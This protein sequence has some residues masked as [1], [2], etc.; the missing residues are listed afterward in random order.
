MLRTARKLEKLDFPFAT[1]NIILLLLF[2]FIVTGSIVGKNETSVA[3]PLTSRL[4]T[5]RLPRPLLVIDKAG[6]LYLDEVPTS[7]PRAIA[8]MQSNAGR[9]AQRH[10]RPHF[11]GA[12]LSR[13][14]R[15]RADRRHPRADHNAQLAG[16]RM[17]LKRRVSEPAKLYWAIGIAASIALHASG[18]AG[19]IL[20]AERSRAG[21][22]ADR[23]HLLGRG[24]AGRHAGAGARGNAPQRAKPRRWP[25][26]S[27]LPR[28]ARRLLAGS[29]AETLQAAGDGR[30]AAASAAARGHGKP[31]AGNRPAGCFTG[32]RRRGQGREGHGR[33]RQPR[34]SPR[35][36]APSICPLRGRQTRPLRSARPRK[37][38]PR[39]TG[40]ERLPSSS[41]ADAA[42][43]VWR[44]R[45]KNCGAGATGRHRTAAGGARCEDPQL[46][47]PL[48]PPLEASA[49][50]EALSPLAPSQSSG[51]PA[52]RIRAG[53]G[54]ARLF[55]LRRTDR[56]R[57]R[58]FR[59]TGDGEP[60]QTFG[61]GSGVR[62]A[63]AH[64]P[65]PGRRHRNGHG[66]RLRPEL[67]T[68]SRRPRKP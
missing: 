50:D 46:P 47:L 1:I 23:D 12:A 67:A 27:D 18:V 36:Q 5:E 21:R 11:P 13:Y 2:F 61:H 3:P 29:A 63:S 37:E 32:G 20:L 55:A 41:P 4:A 31:V 60:V 42:S 25:N 66:A 53:E 24:L 45:G 35:R 30:F 65:A 7:L 48:S 62:I 17:S 51:Q 15:D 8:R 56:S 26:G 39:R 49:P 9:D 64:C 58:P 57:G 19:A 28:Q 10:R 34:R 6:A 14:H 38:L 59:A 52:D 16:R 43:P 68:S 54:A 44:N 22:R 33:R 40:P